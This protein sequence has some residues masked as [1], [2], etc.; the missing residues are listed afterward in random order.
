MYVHLSSTSTVS[1]SNTSVEKYSCNFRS[2]R[3][4]SPGIGPQFKGK[5][6]VVTNTRRPDERIIPFVRS[7]KATAQFIVEQKKKYVDFVAIF[8]QSWMP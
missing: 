3:Y 2:Y 1:P 6:H 5:L 4:S 8:I 7:C